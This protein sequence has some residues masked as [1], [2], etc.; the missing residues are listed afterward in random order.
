[1]VMKVKTIS[2]SD[3]AHKAIIDKQDEIYKKYKVKVRIFDLVSIIIIDD[4]DN[5]EKLLGLQR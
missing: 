5:A 4:I 1:M 3:D 2:I